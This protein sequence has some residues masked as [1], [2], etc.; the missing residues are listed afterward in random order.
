M[1]FREND[2]KA[3]R[4]SELAFQCKEWRG[5]FTWRHCKETLVIRAITATALFY[6]WV[7][8]SKYIK[9]NCVK[10]LV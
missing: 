6:P 3:E 9:Y 7:E 1:K 4:D 5:A 2:Q 8:N 10:C